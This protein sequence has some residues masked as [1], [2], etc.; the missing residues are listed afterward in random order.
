MARHAHDRRGT[1]VP[2]G[3]LRLRAGGGARL[4]CVP[5]VGGPF[6]PRGVPRPRSSD[7][8]SRRCTW[9]RRCSCVSCDCPGGARALRRVVAAPH[10]A[11]RGAV[12]AGREARDDRVAGTDHRRVLRQHRGRLHH[13]LHQRGVAR[14]SR[15]R[16]TAAARRATCAIIDENGPV[17]VGR[18]RRGLRSC[19]APTRTSRTSA[20][21]RRAP[22]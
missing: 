16:R 4:R 7:T 6:R 19:G 17:P 3:A 10:L 11:H 12:P 8:G 5:G 20:S 21:P 15:Y 14:P 2:F 9:C 1:D 13:R 18:V 22:R